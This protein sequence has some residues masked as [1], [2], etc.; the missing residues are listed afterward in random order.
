[1]R[2]ALLDGWTSEKV[3]TRQ[4]WAC[5]LTA[6]HNYRD[7]NDFKIKNHSEMRDAW[8]LMTP[9]RETFVRLNRSNNSGTRFQL[10]LVIACVMVLTLGFM[11]PSYFLLHISCFCDFYCPHVFHLCLVNVFASSHFQ[12]VG[13]FW[14][15]LFLFLSLPIPPAKSLLWDKVFG[16]FIL[17]NSQCKWSPSTLLD[18]H[19]CLFTVTFQLP[20]LQ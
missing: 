20:A 10:K 4:I 17:I 14:L 5:R 7:I 16:C 12:S 11:F 13:T 9:S 2:G 1:M 18:D 3:L 6:S 15:F 19:R 8:N